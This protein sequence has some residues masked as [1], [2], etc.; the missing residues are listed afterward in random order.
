MQKV[1]D[2]FFRNPRFFLIFRNKLQNNLISEKNVIRKRIKLNKNSKMLDFGCGTGDFCLLFDMSQYTGVDIDDKFI[3][4]NKSRFKG[5]NFI[6]VE[7]GKSLPFRGSYFDKILVFGVLHHISDNS[8][9]QILMELNRVLSDSG[10][11]LLYDQLP[12]DEQKKFFAK[13]LVKFDRGKFLRGSEQLKILLKNHFKI[14][15]NYKI[16]SGPYTLCVFVLKKS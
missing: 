8:I 9:K 3:E 16:R 10:E 2:Y 5:Y 15:E 12:S 11:V 1:I 14:K 4:F 13:V 6:K 7:E